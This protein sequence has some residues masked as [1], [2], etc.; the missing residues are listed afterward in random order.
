MERLRASG[1]AFRAVFA[2]ADLRRIELALLGSMLGT[3]SYT[4]ALAVYAYRSGGA[5]AVAIAA[6][7]RWIPAALAAP[8]MSILGDRLPRRRVMLGADLTR[9][10]LMG[11]MAAIALSAGPHPLVYAL[12]ACS[13]I[14]GTAFRPAQSALLPSLARTPDELTAANVVSTTIESVGYFGGPALGGLLLAATSPGWVFLANAGALTWSA[15]NVWRI[16]S[17]GERREAGPSGSFAS[18]ALAGFRTIA[19]ESRV[20]LLMGMFAVQVFV[21]GALG[22]LVVVLALEQIRVGS[23]GLG[24]LNGAMGVG[25]VLGGVAAAAL[26]GRRRLAGDFGFGILLWGLPIALIG[27][28]PRQWL[29]L[30]A[31]ALV[32]VGN[33]IVDVTGMTLLQRSVPDD[34]LARVFG[35]METVI[36]GASSLGA[37]LAPVGYHALGLRTTLVIT[38]LLLPALALLAAPM[39]HAIDAEAVPP[40]GLERLRSVPFLALLPEPTLE[41]L[42]GRLVPVH[43]EAGEDVIREGERGDRFYVIDAGEVEIAG[44]RHGRGAYFGE[45]A[46]LRDVRRTATVHAVTKLD[47]LALERDDFL[48]AVTGHAPSAEAANVVI[49]SRV[50]ALSG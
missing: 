45:I 49:A 36:Y 1:G 23:S 28:W 24:F 16:T 20:R 31:L 47:L 43:V 38:G 48:A 40:A 4:L 33:T 34:V 26:V 11:G 14:C 13:S 3:W 35:V 6:I 21:D 44:G 41:S 19:S 18:A 27:L 8:W 9:I 2:N 37:V 39:L 17:Y 22:V 29:G 42:A 25:G 15:L 7:V 50:P 30:V 12:A 32:G 46:L 10:A 5:S